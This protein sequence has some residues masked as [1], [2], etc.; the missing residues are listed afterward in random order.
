MLQ[1]QAV[2]TLAGE[3]RDWLKA[4]HHFAVDSQGNPAHAR[5]GYLVVWNDDE[6]APHSGIP[7][8]GRRNTEIVAEVG[9][10]HGLANAGALGIAITALERAEIIRVDTA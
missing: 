5:L 1:A 10:R 7:R 9:E 3:H 6:I 8:R 4:R 2:D